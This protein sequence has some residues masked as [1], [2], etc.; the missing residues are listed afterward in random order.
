MSSTVKM[1]AL[2]I[3]I[4]LKGKTHRGKEGMERMF[5]PKLPSEVPFSVD[6]RPSLIVQKKFYSKT[7]N[8]KKDDF[9]VGFIE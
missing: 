4:K 9:C 3:L 2:S 8:K 5:N 1:S 6:C 7:N